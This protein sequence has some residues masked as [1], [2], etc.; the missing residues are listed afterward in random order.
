MHRSSG[1]NRHARRPAP[2]LCEDRIL[3]SIMVEPIGNKATQPQ[4]T[5]YMPDRTRYVVLDKATP[6]HVSRLHDDPFFF[7]PTG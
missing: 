4:V 6:D 1:R 5:A 2:E 7:E 3:Q